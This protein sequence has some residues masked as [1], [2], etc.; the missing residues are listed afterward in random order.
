MR[1]QIQREYKLETQASAEYTGLDGTARG[2]RADP[3]KVS[4]GEASQRE[5]DKDSRTG[6]GYP[7]RAHQQD[8]QGE[9]ALGG[10]IE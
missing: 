9:E 4:A 10:Q 1:R 6:L 2:R 8:K 5:Q 7:G 3:A